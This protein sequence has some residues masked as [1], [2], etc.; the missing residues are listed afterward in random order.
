MDE[1]KKPESVPYTVYEAEM[2][3]KDKANRRWFIAWLITFL[4]LVGGFV[5]FVFYEQQ[6]EDVVITAEQTASDTGNNY[7]VGGDFIGDTTEGNH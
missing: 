1:Q 7:A 5:G 4:F 6:F 3:R 2:A